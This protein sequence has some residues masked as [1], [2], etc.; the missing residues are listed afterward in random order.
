MWIGAIPARALNSGAKIAKI[1]IRK[2][3]SRISF[4]RVGAL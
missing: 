2:L 1:K 3:Q 4:F